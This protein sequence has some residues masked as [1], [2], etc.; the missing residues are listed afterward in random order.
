MIF[1]AANPFTKSDST[2]YCSVY[3][4]RYYHTAGNRGAHAKRRLEHDDTARTRSLRDHAGQLFCAEIIGGL[5]RAD[6]SSRTSKD[7]RAQLFEHVQ[8]YAHPILRQ[9]TDTGA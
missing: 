1:A 3:G 6:I 8:Y 2:A 5:M 4:R 7:I 9:A